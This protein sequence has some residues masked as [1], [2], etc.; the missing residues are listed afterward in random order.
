MPSQ[1]EAPVSVPRGTRVQQGE[2]HLRPEGGAGDGD[3][4][5]PFFLNA[6]A[7]PVNYLNHSF[8]VEKSDDISQNDNYFLYL[9]LE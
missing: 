8:G 7:I 6:P 9:P 2:G 4:I 5:T 1:E 3:Y